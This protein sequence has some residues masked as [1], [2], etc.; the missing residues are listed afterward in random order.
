MDFWTGIGNSVG[1]FANGVG[2]V[3]GDIG[4]NALDL[5][6]NGGKNV[7]YNATIK[8]ASYN[9]WATPTYTAPTPKTVPSSGSSSSYDAQIDYWNKKAALDAAEAAQRRATEPVFINY[10]IGAS[11]AKAK[12]MAEQAVSPVYQQKMTDFINRQAQELGRQN[13]D[14]TSGKSAL[15]TALSRLMG[16]TQVQRERTTQDTAT[17]IGD[18]NASQAYNT[19]G[20]SL[21]FDAANKAL[22]EGVGASGMATSGIGQQ[23]IQDAQASRR[24][25]SNETIRQSNNKV[26]AQNT[27]MNRTFEDLTTQETRGTEDT[28]QKKSKLDLDLER[29]IEDQAY[30]KD[31]ETKI[32]EAQKQADIASKSIGLQGQLVDQWLA[33]L[34]GKYNAASIANAAQ[35]YK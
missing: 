28:T 17:N 20:E 12:Q 31:Q 14:T 10:D 24:D 34:Q 26:D 2:S 27:L 35:I 9:P 21:N 32:E 1:G 29:F 4:R 7:N 19:R 13:E 6:T 25:V 11:W 16:D 8:A 23:Q 30:N 33:S 18:I 22:T 15:D 5:L 3:V